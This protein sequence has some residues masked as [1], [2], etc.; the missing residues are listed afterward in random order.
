[1]TDIGPILQI[2]RR[3]NLLVIEDASQAHGARYKG[4]RVGSLGDAAAFSLYPAK[5]LGAYG[6]AGIVVTND[7][8]VAERVRLLRNYGSVKK[9]HHQV[10]G[11]NR[12]LDTLH[13]AILRVKLRYLDQWN[14]ARRRHAQRYNTLLDPKVA[15]CPFEAS[16]EEPVYHLYVIRA[17]ERD[18]LQAHLSA[19]GIATVIHYPIPIHLQPAYRHLGYREGDFPVTEYY[20]QHILS[21]PM[22]AELTAT[23]IEYVS[24]AVKE[25]GAVGAVKQPVLQFA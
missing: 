13:A 6:D 12:R 16:Y 4:R 8:K 1:V 25:F 14:A 11:F 19:K 18:A 7:P 23:Q 2:A 17:T 9:Y 15:K 5:N 20:S 21:L 10:E 3:H 22:Y 24:A